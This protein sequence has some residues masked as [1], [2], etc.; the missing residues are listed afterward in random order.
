MQPRYKMQTAYRLR[1]K[2]LHRLIRDIFTMYDLEV[3]LLPDAMSIPRKF[4]T[5]SISLQ[6]N[7]QTMTTC[8]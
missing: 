5:K 4:P 1:P 8:A 7:R 2:L 6:K 3:I